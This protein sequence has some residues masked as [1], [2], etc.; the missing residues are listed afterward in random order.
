MSTNDDD[1][2][3]VCN[4]II[5]NMDKKIIEQILSYIQSEWK[6][7]NLRDFVKGYFVSKFGFNLNIVH[8][9]NLNKFEDDNQIHYNEYLTKIVN[10]KKLNDMLND[11]I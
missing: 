2:E 5:K 1:M 3:S 6:V 11:L 10:S 9:L 7:D 4:E 8:Q